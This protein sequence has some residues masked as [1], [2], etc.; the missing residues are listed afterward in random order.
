M[1]APLV[2][3][4][5]ALIYSFAVTTDWKLMLAG[6]AYVVV[7]SLLLASSAGKRPARG[8]ITRRWQ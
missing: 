7:P 2:P 8:R 1:L 4:F 6:T 3:L 5:A